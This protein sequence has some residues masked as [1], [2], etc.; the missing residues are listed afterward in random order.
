MCLT[1]LKCF[2]IRAV[3]LLFHHKSAMRFGNGLK[4][5]TS[6]AQ[7]HNLHP[8]HHISHQPLTAITVCLLVLNGSWCHFIVAMGR[9][10]LGPIPFTQMIHAWIWSDGGM[11]LT[12][13]TK[14]SEKNL[15]Q[16]LSFK[17][18]PQWPGCEF[19]SPWWEADDHSKADHTGTSV[20]HPW[21]TV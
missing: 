1:M 6:D 16:P 15:S 8:R 2:L 14:N 11:I 3:Y 17:Q 7:R 12:G 20:P 9:D 18:I 4:V 10:T 13:E 21:L 19:G 5:H